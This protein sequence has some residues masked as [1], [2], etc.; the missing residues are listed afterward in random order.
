MQEE[1]GKKHTR[2]AGAAGGTVYKEV[3]VSLHHQHPSIWQKLHITTRICK[4]QLEDHYSGSERGIAES[5]AVHIFNFLR[6]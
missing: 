5:Q 6:C 3:E 2:V 4:P 1:V